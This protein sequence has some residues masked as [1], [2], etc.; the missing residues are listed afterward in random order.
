[1]RADLEPTSESLTDGNAGQ[2][3]AVAPPARAER[4]RSGPSLAVARQGAVAVFDQAIFSATTFA[5]TVILGR[6]C[7]PDS[8]GVYYLAFTAVLLVQGIQERLISTPYTI[9]CNRRHRDALASYT[10]SVLLHQLLLCLAVGLGLAGLFAAFHATGVLP[11]LKPVIYVLMGALPLLMLRS[12]VRLLLIAHLEMVTAMVLDVAVAALQL[13]GLLV[14]GELRLLTVP[15]AYLVMGGASGAVAV[16]WFLVKRPALRFARLRVVEDW[17]HNWSFA[18]WVVASN[19]AGSVAIYAGPWILNGVRGTGATALLGACASLVGLSNMFVAGLD[20]YLTP[21]AARAFSRQGIPGLISL[22]W[23]S[24]IFLAILLGGLCLLFV[25]AGEPLAAIVYKNKYVGA[26]PI[27]S[28]L[29]ASVLINALGN[30]A[31]R[32]LW[33]LDR[34][35]DNFLP[36]AAISLVTLAVLCALVYP[37]GAWGAAIATVAGNLAGALIRTWSLVAL[38]RSLRVEGQWRRPA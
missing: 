32:G 13:G 2:P 7:D 34:P 21:K 27:V 9:Y 22:L 23:R 38:L 3:L 36:D 17:W 19:L 14:L 16:A 37:Y 30:S 5:T 1:M 11:D 33:V 28:L 6:L 26:G 31:G 29:A 15:S 12:F 20:S 35:R 4:P 10:G 18:K 24:S 25:F 8:F